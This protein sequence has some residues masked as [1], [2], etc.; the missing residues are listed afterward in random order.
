MSE[1]Q[2]EAGGSGQ[3]DPTAERED[4]ERPDEEQPIPGTVPPLAGFVAG[5][6]ARVAGAG[7]P[8]PV[9]GETV[10]GDD[11]EHRAAKIEGRVADQAVAA[12]DVPAD[13]RET[14]PA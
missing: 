1:Q 10:L 14:R 2:A 3:P 11:D 9:E 4:P 6:A 7:V 12:S 13:G 8:F 5:A